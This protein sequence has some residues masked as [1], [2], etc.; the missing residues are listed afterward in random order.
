VIIRLRGPPSV[1]P[2][3]DRCHPHYWLT[4]WLLERV[5]DQR[6]QVA[7]VHGKHGSFTGC[8]VLGS[9]INSRWRARRH[10][11]GRSPRRDGEKSLRQPHDLS[12]P[13]TAVHRKSTNWSPLFNVAT[14][15][16]LVRL[17]TLA[18]HHYFDGTLR[19]PFKLSLT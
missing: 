8:A 17:L 12:Q 19:S 14:R 11:I 7:Q 10:G 2:L 5:C 13:C 6:S 15:K 1:L 9:S 3:R 16:T 4:P 18:R